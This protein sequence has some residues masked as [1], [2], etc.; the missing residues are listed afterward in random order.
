MS[1]KRKLSVFTILFVVL[2]LLGTY[3]ITTEPLNNF[4]ISFAITPFT[5]VFSFLGNLI[6]ICLIVVVVFL[7]SKRAY[8]RMRILVIISFILSLLG[9]LLSIYIRYYQ[10]PFSLKD[11]S[12]AKYAE[13]DMTTSIID[14]VLRE[15]ILEFKIVLFLNFFIMLVVYIIFSKDKPKGIYK[16]EL[17]PRILFQN[18]KLLFSAMIGLLLLSFIHINVVYRYTKNNWKLDHER[19]LYG[20]QASGPYNFYFYDLLGFDWANSG[21]SRKATIEEV[22][23][24]DKNVSKYTNFF[25]ETYSNVLNINDASTVRLDP[26]LGDVTTL[27][28][29]FADKNVVYIQLETLNTFLI[30]GSSP[31][32]EELNL[33]PDFKKLIEES[34]FFENFYSNVGL[35]NSSDAEILALTGLY[36][37]GNNLM[38]WQ[39][40]S[41][42][43][44]REITWHDKITNNAY[45]RMI[46]FRL[47]PLPKVL[48]D[49]YSASFHADNR[50]FY[51]RENTHPGMLNFDDFYHF[52][53]R[54]LPD[55][56]GTTN[57]V[58][59]F[60]G[61]LEKNPGSP[62]VGEKDLFEWVKIVAKEKAANGEKY[63]LY[64]ITI[65]PH[66]PYLYDPY[67]DEPTI[68]R[69]D[70]RLNEVTITYINYLRFYND[71]FK[72]IIDLAN[73]LENTIFVIY[74]DHGTGFPLNDMKTLLNRPDLLSVEAWEKLY[75][76]PALIYAPNDNNSVNGMKSGLLTG[77]QPLVRSQV[78]L[79]RTVLEL[80][81]KNE[82]HFYY[83][84]NGLSDERTFAL[85]TRISL[86]I[87][88]DFTIQLKKYCPTKKFSRDSIV[89]HNGYG[90][91][92]YDMAEMIE[93][94][95]TFKQINDGIINNNMVIDVNRKKKGQ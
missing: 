21:E 7:C 47:N 52:T 43:Y 29:I 86:L 22:M 36:T 19:P 42:K 77:K 3:F 16:K 57:A 40:G 24:Y 65:H 14:V 78:D 72:M 39:Y 54:I 85:Q 59:A 62:W 25:G 89:Y 9:Y 63:F 45:K 93:K 58:D 30:D 6:V 28:G 61:H 66:T 41:N 38:Y 18:T 82:Q 49:Y 50:Q 27:N 48:N 88:D 1:I 84:V 68:T 55:K 20:M 83:G 87:T 37:P 44:P 33:M 79:Y 64:P 26:S 76:V 17:N 60:P 5:V 46:D 70:I 94:I 81:G 74:G 91:I 69:E 75:Q 73:E 2:S 53:E 15:L 90:P 56:I 71:V 31:F 8:N 23:L 95:L 13:T 92:D 10:S 32:L 11:L 51:N 4:M 12:F 34:Y 67:I 80:L 35:G